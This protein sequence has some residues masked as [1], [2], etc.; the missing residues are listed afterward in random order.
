MP[1]GRPPFEIT[2]IVCQ[3]AKHLAAGGC[4]L[5]QIATSLGIGLSTTC[6][7]KKM[8]REFREA[9]EDGRTGALVSM[10]NALYEKGLTGDTTAMKFYLSNRDSDSWRE[11]QHTELSGSVGIHEDCL[12]ELE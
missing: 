9:I 1:G 10:T 4:T 3:K 8:F 7:K 6:R 2:D 5:E 11:K 12:D